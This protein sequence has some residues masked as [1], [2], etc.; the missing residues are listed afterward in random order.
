MSTPSAP[1]PALFMDAMGAYQRTA[2]IR[3]AIELGV[4]T[5]IGP[6][7]ADVTAVAE[8]CQASERGIRALCDFLT[9]L[10]FLI[11]EEGLYRLTQDSAIFLDRRSPA[12]L[13]GVTQ[14]LLNPMVMEG[15]ATLTEAV[16]KGGTAI[17]PEGSIAPEHPI[18][19]DFA[20]AMGPLM[21]QGATALAELLPFDA[22]R[23][24]K[25]LDI[26]AGHGFYGIHVA[27]RFPK[28]EITA[29]DWPNVLQVAQENAQAAGIGDR[30]KVIAGSAFDVELGAGYDVV[31][32]T[33]FLH[34]FDP[35][36]C[37]ALLR[38]IR[39]SLAEGG[40]VA[41]V[42]IV[43]DPDRASPVPA[44]AFSM[45]MLATTPSGDA[46]TFAE[47]EGMAKRAG[48]SRTDERPLFPPANKVLLSYT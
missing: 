27:R 26:A 14:F 20:R 19:V 3:A 41:T 37:E 16:R 23:P 11:K 36:T 13:G 15:F 10:G 5:A 18:W 32:L 24:L 45:V 22:D 25:V 17:S 47:I 1:S 9:G 43:L 42:E 7:P 21:L 29:L 12:Y 33:G 48:F 4:F 44:A 40:I 31:L 8:R 2:A 30:Y 34:H 38:K 28:A 46:Y 35:P 6:D 39:A